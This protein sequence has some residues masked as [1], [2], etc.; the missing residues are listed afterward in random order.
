MHNR[1]RKHFALPYE[2]EYTAHRSDDHVRRVTR[3]HLNLRESV[4]APSIVPQAPKIGPS[5][6]KKNSAPVE[7]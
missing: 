5:P 1:S 3:L 7:R 4:V 6:Q 2:P